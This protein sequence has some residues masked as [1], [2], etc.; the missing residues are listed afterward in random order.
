[1]AQIIIKGEMATVT[2]VELDPAEDIYGLA[3]DKGAWCAQPLDEYR[4]TD[5]ADLLM[6]ADRHAD[7]VRHT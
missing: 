4:T 1:M 3:C 2:V 6:E 5:V 7:C